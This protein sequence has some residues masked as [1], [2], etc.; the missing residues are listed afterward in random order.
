MLILIVLKLFNRLCLWNLTRWSFWH[1]SLSRPNIASA[2]TCSISTSQSVI[3]CPNTHSFILIL[4]CFKYCNQNPY[5]LLITGF[6]SLSSILNAGSS[7]FQSSLCGLRA[8]RLSIYLGVSCTGELIVL[9]FLQWWRNFSLYLYCACW[10]FLPGHV[11]AACWFLF[12]RLDPEVMHRHRALACFSYFR[13]AWNDL[14]RFLPLFLMSSNWFS[15]SFWATS[16]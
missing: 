15:V 3:E 14:R 13:Q 8:F 4:N 5:W 7:S 2:C 11:L 6:L 16:L 12:I 10:D 9:V 1:I